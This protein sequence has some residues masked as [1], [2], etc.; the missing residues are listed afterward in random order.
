[1]TRSVFRTIAI[2][3]TITLSCA[4]SLAQETRAPSAGETTSGIIDAEKAKA[5]S[6]SPVAPSH[7]EQ[8][9]DRFEEKIFDP[10]I[11]PNGPTFQLGGLPTGGRILSW[12]SVHPARLATRTFDQRQLPRRLNKEVVQGAVNSRFRQVDG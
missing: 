9:F 7:G 12:P 6:L 2:C 1:M 11:V 5:N 3:T 10:L 8:E 4:S